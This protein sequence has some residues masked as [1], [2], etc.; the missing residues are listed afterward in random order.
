MGSLV[1]N[2][3]GEMTWYQPSSWLLLF[4]SW[5][6]VMDLSH[7]PSRTSTV[8]REWKHHGAPMHTMEH[9]NHWTGK[10]RL[11]I[12]HQTTCLT[13]FLSCSVLSH[14]HFSTPGLSLLLCCGPREKTTM[15]IY[16]VYYATF[17]TILDRV[18]H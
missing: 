3:E 8:R 13:K 9:H 6:V 2:R 14:A 5:S 10:Q 7:Q 18:V 15:M 4:A 17:L 11:Y 12:A 16:W 1:H